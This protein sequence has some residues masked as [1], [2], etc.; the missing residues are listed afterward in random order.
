M[1]HILLVFLGGGLG[2]VARY[3]LSRAMVAW[4]GTSLFPLGTFIAN[5]LGCLLIGY[6]LATLQRYEHI[7][8]AW[9]LLLATGFC[10]GFTTFSSFAY[11]NN[12]LARNLEY[13]MLFLYISLSLVLGLAATF[14]GMWLAGVMK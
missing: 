2:S 6:I 5:L 3:L 4:W 1:R 10:G 8:V 12:L 14:L 9:S 7:S 13:G 11:E